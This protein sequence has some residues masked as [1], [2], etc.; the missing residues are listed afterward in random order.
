M[1]APDIMI[2]TS[3]RYL[4]CA[5]LLSAPFSSARDTIDISPYGNV[6]ADLLA[7]FHAV[8]V[9]CEG[10]ATDVGEMCFRAQATSASYLAERLIDIVSDYG[11]VGLDSGGW[12]SGNGVWT[13]SLMLP[14]KNL[15]H[16]EIYLAEVPENGVKGVI[17]LVAPR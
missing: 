15:G 11:S 7:A 1:V 6:V 3:L 4:L 14:N 9:P 10:V 17:R 16:L 5:L 8:D 2:R 12:R 13:V